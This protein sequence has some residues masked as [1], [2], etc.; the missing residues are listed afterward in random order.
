MGGC[1]CK[2]TK[3]VLAEMPSNEL[4]LTV[5]PL[6]HL[7]RE[8]G[9][10]EETLTLFPDKKFATE[11]FADE[12]EGY[13]LTFQNRMKLLTGGHVTGYDVQRMPTADGRVIVRVIQNVS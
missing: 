5:L 8:F 3:A 13:I 12:V 10:T 4:Y 6:I 1:A 7:G 11:F 2:S 9:R